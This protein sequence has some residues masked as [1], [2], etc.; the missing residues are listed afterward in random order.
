MFA[1]PCGFSA[2]F[3][4]FPRNI[5]GSASLSSKC[6]DEHAQNERGPSPLS[7]P[8]VVTTVS[9]R[10]GHRRRVPE[11]S[12][13]PRRSERSSSRRTVSGQCDR[14][15]EPRLQRHQH[16]NLC[17]RAKRSW[18]PRRQNRGRRHR[19]WWRS[20]RSDRQRRLCLG[21]SGH[22][23]KLLRH[24]RRSSRLCS[25][26]IRR[27]DAAA[28]AYRSRES[29]PK[30]A[31]QRPGGS[32]T[33][34]RAPLAVA[35]AGARLEQVPEEVPEE[36]S[37]HVCCNGMLGMFTAAC[38]STRGQTRSWG[39]H[40]CTPLPA[41]RT[42]DVPMSS[43]CGMEPLLHVLAETCTRA[44]YPLC[45][46]CPIGCSLPAVRSGRG[47]M[48]VHNEQMCIH[49]KQMCIRNELICTHARRL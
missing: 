31:S 44:E 12:R 3:A 29:T 41:C 20:H 5:G 47:L 23:T 21:R 24:R 11:Q 49:N 2:V 1:C 45:V 15:A 40:C 36:V 16:R 39:W 25:L 28:G 26:F 42:A 17:R 4:F 7:P 10:R 22:G 19:R 37:R 13:R 30:A 35:P 18:R 34:R 38:G 46:G 6:A 8:L 33:K 9:C 48:C 43:T 27:L 32:G 14:G